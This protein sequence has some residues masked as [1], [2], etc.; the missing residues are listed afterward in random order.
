MKYR[1]GHCFKLEPVGENLAA[2]FAEAEDQGNW[3]VH[4]DGGVVGF[5]GFGNDDRQWIFKF[6]RPGAKP[7][8]SGKQSS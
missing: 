3:A 5:F 2:E 4:F 6:L 8:T 1:V 7:D